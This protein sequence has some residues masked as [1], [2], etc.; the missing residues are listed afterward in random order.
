M[1]KAGIDR[2]TIAPGTGYAI[3]QRVGSS[4]AVEVN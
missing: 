4:D 1:E 2:L 3:L